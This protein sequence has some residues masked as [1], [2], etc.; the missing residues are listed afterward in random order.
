M[1][2]AN[3]VYCGFTASQSPRFSLERV[4]NIYGPALGNDGIRILQIE[5]GQREQSIQCTLLEGFSEDWINDYIALSYT[6]GSVNDVRTIHSLRLPNVTGRIWV[7]SV[8]INQGDIDDRTNQVKRMTQIYRDASGVFIWL[9]PLTTTTSVAV[10]LIHAI[11]AKGALGNEAA[12]SK[13]VIVACGQYRMDWDSL[14]YACSIAKQ[15]NLQGFR[16][17]PSQMGYNRVLRIGA[18][19]NALNG[20]DPE[21]FTLEDLLCHERSA[22]ATDDR[23]KVFSLLGLA[24]DIN[25]QGQDTITPTITKPQLAKNKSLRFLGVAGALPNQGRYSLPSWVPDWSIASDIGPIDSLNMLL[26]YST[27][28][29]EKGE[30]HFTN[31]GRSL[32]LKGILFDY[33]LDIGTTLKGY[34][35]LDSD[36]IDSA[37]AS[38]NAMIQRYSI[39]PG[40]VNNKLM[41]VYSD[42]RRA[43]QATIFGDRWVEGK[44][45][46]AE[47]YDHYL[48]WL[49]WRQ[50]RVGLREI[51]Y[52]WDMVKRNSIFLCDKRFRE[53]CYGRRLFITQR[54]FIGIAIET[55]SKGDAVCIFKG[56]RVPCILR[57][58]LHFIGDGQQAPFQVMEEWQLIGDAYLHGAMDGQGYKRSQIREFVIS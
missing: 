54:G 23:D 12:V 37:W 16:D 4:G 19:Q 14:F 34:A 24:S 49:E 15:A 55:M 10:N 46:D 3:K 58:L 29:G 35:N 21:G 17:I 47:H 57:Q 28:G 7:D 13:G 25:L 42:L 22:L 41:E 44:I 18:Y 9:G 43:F 5:P 6:W 38:W 50:D 52:D 30:V 11:N 26:P 40:S 56:G 2:L 32:V 8:C 45:L 20:Y 31:H 27:S 48:P 36:T 1:P 39:K 33:V 51:H 53:F